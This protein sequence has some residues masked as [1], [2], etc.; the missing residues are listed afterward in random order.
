MQ[1]FLYAIRI[2]ERRELHWQTSLAIFVSIIF[3]TAATVWTVGSVL[4]LRR[5]EIDRRLSR[6]WNNSQTI[7]ISDGEVL[8]PV[9]VV[10]NPND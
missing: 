7:T 6:V 4:T 5:T 1:A 8:P 10:T 2:A 3:A 9:D